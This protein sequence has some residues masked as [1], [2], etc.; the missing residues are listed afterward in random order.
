M[1][2]LMLATLL[3][4]QDAVDYCPLKPGMKWTYQTDEGAEVV[5]A[6]REGPEPGEKNLV[7]VSNFGAWGFFRKEALVRVAKDAIEVSRLSTST[8]EFMWLRTPL[9]PGEKWISKIKLNK[10]DAELESAV[11]GEEEIEVPAGKFKCVKVKM[12]MKDAEGT[13]GEFT[14][15]Y[16]KGVGEVSTALTVENGRKRLKLTRKLVKFEPVA[17]A[18]EAVATE[19]AAPEQKAVQV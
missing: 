13:G 9:K 5:K 16:A 1:T 17:P 19:E 14:T 10:V 15:W 6:V 3:V 4:T 12:V 8:V 7:S 2:I 11:E 18:S